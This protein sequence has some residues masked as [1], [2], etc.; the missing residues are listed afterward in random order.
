MSQNGPIA[1]VNSSAETITLTPSYK[2]GLQAN[3]TD[4]AATAG[5]QTELTLNMRKPKASANDKSIMKL[6]VPFEVVSGDV[7]TVESVTVFVD[8]VSSNL[9]SAEVRQNAITLTRAALADALIV[10][11]VTANGFPY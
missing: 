4:R 11:L 10:D 3:Y 6:V 5:M 7:T 8:V 9:A 1:V 2:E